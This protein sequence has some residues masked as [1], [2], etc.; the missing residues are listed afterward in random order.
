MKATVFFNDFH[1]AFKTYNRQDNFSCQGLNALFD[2]LEQ[3]EED[4]GMEEAI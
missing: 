4:C 2:Y 1:E 3:Y